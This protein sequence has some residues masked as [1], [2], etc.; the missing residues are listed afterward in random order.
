M[1]HTCSVSAT[2]PPFGLTSL[3]LVDVVVDVFW[4]IS[5]LVIS[6]ASEYVKGGSPSDCL[7]SFKADKYVDV[8]VL[9]GKGREGR[10]GVGRTISKYS[11]R[12]AF[13]RRRVAGVGV[14]GAELASD[15]ELEGLSE[16]ETVGVAEGMLDFL[17]SSEK[18]RIR[19]K[20]VFSGEQKRHFIGNWC[21]KL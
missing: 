16:E 17:R 12:V 5:A 4:V 8:E 20:K 19:K 9:S 2:G 15:C 11:V 1:E 10:M 7:L 21:A 13:C 14:A 18:V 3:L 6:M